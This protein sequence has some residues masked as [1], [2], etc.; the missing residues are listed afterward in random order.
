MISYYA[1]KPK[2]CADLCPEARFRVAWRHSTSGTVSVGKMSFS[3]YPAAAEFAQAMNAL[4]P[5]VP[6]WPIPADDAGSRAC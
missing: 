2:P 6:H 5:D 1:D 4:W 3:T